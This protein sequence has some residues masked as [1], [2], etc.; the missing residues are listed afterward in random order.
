MSQWTPLSCCCLDPDDARKACDCHGEKKKTSAGL[1]RKTSQETEK[2]KTCQE[3][4]KRKTSV[5]VIWKN[6]YSHHLKIL[7][8]DEC[9]SHY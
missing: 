6:D 7:G 2:R 9:W 1:E 8:N 5:E 4:E 3:T